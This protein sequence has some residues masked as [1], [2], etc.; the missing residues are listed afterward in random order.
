MKVYINIYLNWQQ[1]ISFLNVLE[2]DKNFYINLVVT[3]RISLK[4]QGYR[5]ASL[6]LSSSSQ[7]IQYF[8]AAKDESGNLYVY[9]LM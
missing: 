6:H 2:F 4:L 7:G 1:N 3:L 9:L 5:K 8:F